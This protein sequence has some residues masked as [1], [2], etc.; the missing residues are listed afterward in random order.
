MSPFR[1]RLSLLVPAA[2]AVL[3]AASPLRAD[4]KILYYDQ[5]GRLTGIEGQSPDGAKPETD[6]DRAGGT[7]KS[8]RGSEDPSARSG[9]DGAGLGG[10]LAG[11]PFSQR[12]EPGEIVVADPPEG[13]ELRARQLGFSV[14]GRA[15]LRAL[16]VEVL[17]LRVPRGSSVPA[18][19]TRLRRQ[20]PGLAVDAN[21]LLDPSDGG[22]TP[23]RYAQSLMGWGAT[24]ASC[25]RGVK[26]GVID[27]AVDP[28]HPALAGGALEYRSFH[29]AQRRPGAIEHGT[30]IA[31]MLIGQAPWGGLL[32]AAELKHA[33][34]FELSADG[35]VTANVYGLVQGLDWIAAKQVHVINLSVAGSSNH[36]LDQVLVKARR[37]GFI[38]VAAAGNGGPKAS[39]AY[40]AAYDYVISVTAVDA[41]QR[42]YEHANRG[43]YVEFAA[44]GVQIWTAV[45][46]GGRLQS[47]T[48]FA[49]P[50]VSV[51]IGLDAARK[52]ATDPATARAALRQRLVDLG[53]PGRDELFGWGLVTLPRDC[54]TQTAG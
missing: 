47:G 46:G 13:F 24:S 30:A 17:R 3:V 19:V 39:P 10:N 27:G 34:I 45:P 5:N 50:F 8:G 9:T 4:W 36:V 53:A 44:P 11:L 33:N 48:S 1:R 21:H 28:S 35:R 38:L 42:L 52:R 7:G 32:P 43:N 51:L 20:F 22:R 25:G 12:F 26:L 40:P 6:A 2:L 15:S 49:A 41:H 37:K 16:A 14:I 23:E 18:A 54:T 31:T 29:D